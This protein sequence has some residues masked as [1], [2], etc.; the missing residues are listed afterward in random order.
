MKIVINKLID[1]G[2]YNE[3]EAKEHAICL[4][5]PLLLR[6]RYFKMSWTKKLIQEQIIQEEQ[7]QVEGLDEQIEI[8]EKD[9]LFHQNQLKGNVKIKLLLTEISQTPLQMK[10]RKLVSPFLSFMNLAPQFGLFHTALLIGPWKLEFND[11]SLCI[12]KCCVSKAAIITMDIGSLSTL[13]DVESSIETI[14]RVITDWNTKRTYKEIPK[15]KDKE[16]N[17]QSF[18]EELLK[19]LKIKLNLHGPIGEFLKKMREKGKSELVFEY[20]SVFAK[21]YGLE[22]STKSKVFQMHKELDE[23]VLKLKSKNTKFSETEEYQLLKS[24]DRAFWLRLFAT[25][26]SQENYKL[27]TYLEIDGKCACPFENPL[28]TY[29]IV[30]FDK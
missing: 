11:N 1:C 30:H 13:Q 5:H 26:E 29:S 21:K 4:C 15:N 12:P 18:V 24:F 22:G 25:K 16:G 27:F 8:I 28:E 6:N 7:S 10:T 19:A 14:C 23:L 17:C 3:N 2:K 9:L 20:G